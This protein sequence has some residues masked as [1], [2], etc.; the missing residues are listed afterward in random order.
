MENASSIDEVLEFA[1]AREVEAYQLYRY[2]AEQM[3]SPR[4]RQMCIELAEEELEHKAML[5][6]EVMKIGRVVCDFDWSDYIMDAGEE[7][8]MDYEQLLAFAIKKEDT[9]VKLYVELARIVNYAESR[10]TLLALADEEIEHRR[11]FEIEY[12]T[13]KEEY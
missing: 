10:Q 2:M 12:N 5:E 8:D 9:S 13:L 11:R 1:I 7:L 6:L 4:L 3:Q